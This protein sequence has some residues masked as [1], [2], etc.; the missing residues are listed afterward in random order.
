[1]CVCVSPPKLLL[2]NEPN[3]KIGLDSEASRLAQIK[4]NCVNYDTSS[5]LETHNFKLSED[6]SVIL[7][8]S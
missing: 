7:H 5:F 1:M 3:F 4:C 8:Q 6:I 2:L